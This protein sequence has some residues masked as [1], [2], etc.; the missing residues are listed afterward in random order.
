MIK[1]VPE[2]LASLASI[3]QDRNAVYGDDYRRYGRVMLALF[4]EGI[5]IKTEADLS[6]F[7]VLTQMLGKLGRYA[8]NFQSG[9]HAD[10]LDDLAVYAQILQLL[11][12]EAF[13]SFGVPF[14]EC[15]VPVDPFPEYVEPAAP[16]PEKCPTC[17]G[18]GVANG[19]I[20]EACA[21][22]G[23]ADVNRIEVDSEQASGLVGSCPKCG[24][25]PFQLHRPEC[26]I[27]SI[28]SAKGVL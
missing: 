25:A 28:L 11:D 18:V 20:C 22:T 7:G 6:R 19:E 2:R 23:V 27:P 4:P 5:N 13:A 3:Y 17:L 14:P 16:A 9:G 21:G 24:C 26:D 15:A 1:T 8:A 12:H 10:S